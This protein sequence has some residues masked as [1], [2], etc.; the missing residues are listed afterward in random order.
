MTVY[1]VRTRTR[2][3]VAGDSAGRN[4]AAVTAL[5]CGH[6]ETF[7]RDNVGLVNLRREPIEAITV[8]PQ[9]SHCRSPDVLPGRLFR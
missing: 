7:N 8:R 3:L 2:V 9:S 6:C 1:Y 5:Q 4:L